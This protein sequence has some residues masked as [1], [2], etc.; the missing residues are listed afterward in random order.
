MLAV[1]G[2][3]AGGQPG[4]S[5]GSDGGHRSVTARA[6]PLLGA[7]RGGGQVA[8]EP[9]EGEGCAPQPAAEGP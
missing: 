2:G 9:G 7:P 1:S 3:S 4:V 6:V 8:Q 5:R